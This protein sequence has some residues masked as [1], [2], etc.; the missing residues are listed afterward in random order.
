[1]ALPSPPR[2]GGGITKK[3][4]EFISKIPVVGAIVK[5]PENTRLAVDEW[6][7]RL[8]EYGV[9]NIGSPLLSFLWN[10]GAGGALTALGFKEGH[11]DA[12]VIGN[13][14]L[15][16]VL[17][18]LTPDKLSVLQANANQLALSARTLDLEGIK[19]ALLKVKLPEIKLPSLT[20]PAPTPT[21]TQQAPP[22]PAPAPTPTRRFK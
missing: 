4:E 9:D 1:M 13:Y 8:V 10:L 15:T 2:V 22:A 20:P 18:M 21:T 14:W 16:R 7:A 19:N 6:V 17:D 3:I 12:V 11:K 5:L